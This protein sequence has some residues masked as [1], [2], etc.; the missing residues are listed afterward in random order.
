MAGEI[1][2]FNILYNDESIS[3]T[4]LKRWTIY[5]SNTSEMTDRDS[6][7]DWIL[8][9]RIYKETYAE[10]MPYKIVKSARLVLW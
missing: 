6:I 9:M 8:V 5:F 2:T 7:S 3:E 4:H 10:V 1:V